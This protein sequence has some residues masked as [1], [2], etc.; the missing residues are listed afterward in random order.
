MKAQHLLSTA[1]LFFKQEHNICNTGNEI[2]LVYL[3]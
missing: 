3:T 2:S 1:V